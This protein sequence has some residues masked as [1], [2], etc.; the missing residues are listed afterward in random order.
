MDDFSSSVSAIASTFTS[1]LSPDDRIIVLLS[2]VA[3]PVVMS[4]DP[5]LPPVSAVADT[6][7]RM[8]VLFPLLS[9]MVA[10]YAPLE[11]RRKNMKETKEMILNVIPGT[12]FDFNGHP[13]RPFGRVKRYRGRSL[14]LRRF[15][16][17]FH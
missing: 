12:L 16:A 14:S 2:A 11:N 4:P 15:F 6:S 1:V 3:E 10:A 17:L 7:E 5:L 13:A 9:M 8:T